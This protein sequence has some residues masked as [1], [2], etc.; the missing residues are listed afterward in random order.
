MTRRVWKRGVHVYDFNAI[1]KVFTDHDV[2][3]M[4]IVLDNAQSIKGDRQAES[5]LWLEILVGL[6]T[7]IDELGVADKV[8]ATFGLP[9]AP[10]WL[11]KAPEI[12]RPVKNAFVLQFE[13]DGHS[14]LNDGD[15]KVTNI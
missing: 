11:I 8:C 9:G 4:P 3:Y 1:V 13:P 2:E 5:Q 14:P 12:E 6:F 7:A 10:I 15:L